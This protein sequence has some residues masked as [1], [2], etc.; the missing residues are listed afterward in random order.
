MN[1]IEFLTKVVQKA[2]GNQPHEVG[3]L[4]DCLFRFTSRPLN[5]YLNEGVPDDQAYAY[6]NRLTDRELKYI[7]WTMRKLGDMASGRPMSYSN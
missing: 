3:N 5:A 7:K 1:R 4:M 6:L 2:I